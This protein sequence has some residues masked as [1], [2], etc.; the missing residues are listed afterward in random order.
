[1][2]AKVRLPQRYAV[3]QVT[4]FLTLNFL[5]LGDNDIPQWVWRRSSWKFLIDLLK[6]TILSFVQGLWVIWSSDPKGDSFPFQEL[7][8][9]HH[10]SSDLITRMMPLISCHLRTSWTECVCP[11]L[12]LVYW[13]TKSAHPVCPKKACRDREGGG[14]W[15]RC[16]HLPVESSSDWR[17]LC[18]SFY[19][20]WSLAPNTKENFCFVVI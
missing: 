4:S 8:E 20:I 13:A 14:V 12:C 10:I 3:T 17:W 5:I 18:G 9:S 11:F 1:M 16:V 7:I 6:I 15:L 19:N 2:E